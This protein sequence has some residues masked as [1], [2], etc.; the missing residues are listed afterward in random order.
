MRKFH[1]N[2]KWILCLRVR[3]EKNYGHFIFFN[4]AEFISQAVSHL[5]DRTWT[6][7][8]NG[9]AFSDAK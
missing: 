6:L 9:N 7:L 2:R 3:W 5:K 1:R 4:I 8:N